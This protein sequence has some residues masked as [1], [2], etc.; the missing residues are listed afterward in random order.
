V[1]VFGVKH[2]AEVVALINQPERFRPATLAAAPPI[3]IEDSGFLDF[4]DVRGQ[5]TARRAL[6][7]AAAGS[8]NVLL[9]W[10]VCEL[11][12]EAGT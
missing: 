8:H 9:M 10:T 2:L 1:R 3:P 5:T 12:V 6:E 7:V 4:R 11:S